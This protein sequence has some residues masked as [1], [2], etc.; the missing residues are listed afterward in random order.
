MAA[1]R[2][3]ALGHLRVAEATRDELRER[4]ARVHANLATLSIDY[5]R[6][7]TDAD[8]RAIRERAACEDLVRARPHTPKQKERDRQTGTHT[9]RGAR[10]H[11]H[12]RPCIRLDHLA[13]HAAGGPWLAWGARQA[14]QELEVRVLEYRID[15]LVHKRELS[16]ATQ[17][18]RRIPTHKHK[19]AGAH[20]HMGGGERAWCSC[21]RGRPKRCRRVPPRTYRSA[22]RRRRRPSCR[23]MCVLPPRSAA[24]WARPSPP[25][26][27]PRHAGDLNLGYTRWPS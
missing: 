12:T 27:S 5:G 13:K 6:V 7:A 3:L 2:M 8:R 14:L 22:K 15:A 4:Q 17:D 21:G 19:Y 1:K 20:P 10:T 18:V 25:S 24:A 9:H 11:R 26:A 16:Q 23:R